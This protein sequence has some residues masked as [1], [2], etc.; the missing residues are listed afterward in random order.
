MSLIHH[1][2]T[3]GLKVTGERSTAFVQEG[4][5]DASFQKGFV[6]YEQTLISVINAHHM[7]ED[8]VIFPYMR[9]KLTDAPYDELS[10]NH[11][12]IADFLKELQINIDKIATQTQPS[13]ALNAL[14]GTVTKIAEL[15]H[16][17]IAKEQLYIYDPE[18]VDAVMDT[19]EQIKL[20]SETAEY[21]LQQGDRSLMIPFILYN[22]SP[23][24]RA[25]L[26]Q[27][28]PPAVIQELLPGAWKGKWVPMKPFFL[29]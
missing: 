7:S 20:G 18:K 24:E 22:L 9:S 12:V 8:H 23:E 16:P 27:T 15:W 2:I 21:S 13:D 29:D 10:A 3:R 26:A 14:N 25:Y 28:M 17:H 6:T 4:Y 11:L 19:D 1:T 5:P